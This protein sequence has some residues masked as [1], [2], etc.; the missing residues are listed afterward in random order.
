VVQ[1]ITPT[2][3]VVPATKSTLPQGVLYQDDFTDP[4]SG[5]PALEFG[6]YYIGY[7]EPNRYHVE[8]HA[9]ND[10]EIVPIPKQSFDDF[11]AETKVLV[12]ASNTE[13]TGDFRYGLVFRRAGNQYYA[14][15]ISP[16]TKTWS[17]LKS[18]PTGLTV[19]AQG[20]HDS[21][22]G[23]QADDLLRVDAKGPDFVFQ[24]NDQPVGQVSDPD[25]ADGE[26]GFYVE[27]FD[28]QRAHIHYGTTTIRQVETASVL[29]QDDF[30][31]PKSGWPALEFGNYY[32]GYHEPNRY[33]VEV[34]APND[35][36]IVPI[37]QQSFDD[38]TA[39]TKVLVS[40]S[41]TEQTGDFR[42][43]LIFRRAGNQYYAFVISPRTKTWSVLKSSPTGLTVLK[44]GTNDSIVGL[45]ADDLLRVDAKGSDFVFHIND[46]PVGQVSDP[47]Y[48]NGEVG[49]YV[50]TFD[51]Q[52]AHIHYG[53][54]TIRQ[55][56]TTTSATPTAVP[57]RTPS[58]TPTP[59]PS[60]ALDFDWT[61]E[62]QGPNPTNSAEWQIV[63]NILAR[64]GDGNYQY[65]HD[66]LP[67]DGPHIPIIYRGCAGKPGSF[68]LQD[69]TGQVVRKGY[70]MPAPYC[71]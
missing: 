8:V 71:N 31:D 23:L 57:T 33:H 38:F 49:F 60:G 47:D 69:G 9:P 6:N 41:N 54:T 55:V 20:T 36:E 42:Y 45:Q 12:S 26:V 34:H 13:Q 19:L 5:W 21:I 15:V 70:Y 61:I 2:M 44:Q 53:T 29:Y 67:V 40:L 46:Q 7:H 16:R 11:T 64:G 28:S 30:T 48:A 22:Q 43:G 50:E 35:R 52:R 25:Y 51:S 14:F 10:R 27:T 18:S 58:A 37:P 68:W 56:E 65:F 3:T 4:N 1:A 17:V 39:E 24:I 62:S 59:T 32:I 66:G 63:V